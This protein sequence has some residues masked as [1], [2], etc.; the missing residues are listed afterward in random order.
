[1]RPSPIAVELI[2][3]RVADWS[4]GEK[5][6]LDEL[7][8]AT[9]RNPAAL[10]EMPK[11]M[12]VSNLL[13][14]LT[15]EELTAVRQEPWLVSFIGDVKAQDREAVLQW[16]AVAEMTGLVSAATRDAVLNEVLATIPDPAYRANLSW[17]ELALG[18][19]VDADDL[20]AARPEGA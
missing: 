5:A 4:V 16:A 8:A 17:A 19:P 12:T 18:R 9:E 6:I 15:K 2:R 20:R 11:P 7:N 1:M 13:P 14:L 10:L 3:G